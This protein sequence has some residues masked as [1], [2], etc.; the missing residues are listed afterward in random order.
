MS[1]MIFLLYLVRLI[2]DSLENRLGNFSLPSLG[3]NE[4]KIFV[5]ILIGVCQFNTLGVLLVEATNVES[6]GGI[7]FAA[8]RYQR[9]CILL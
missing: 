7:D 4:R 3:D 9:R 1:R 6:I 8:R 5:Q 2:I